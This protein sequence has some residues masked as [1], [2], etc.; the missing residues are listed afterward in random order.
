M[1]F[2]GTLNRKNSPMP[3]PFSVHKN[4]DEYFAQRN[5]GVSFV[6]S[7]LLFSVDL[8][9][10]CHDTDA[11]CAATGDAWVPKSPPCERAAL[12]RGEKS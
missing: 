1:A 8:R 4:E 3:H 11:V 5:S 2:A 6:V 12:N 10:G 7:F 9:R